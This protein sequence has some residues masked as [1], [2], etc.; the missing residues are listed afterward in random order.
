[1]F[2]IPLFFWGQ[3][4]LLYSVASMIFEGA[5]GCQ[6]EFDFHSTPMIDSV[7]DQVSLEP[8]CNDPS[9]RP[10]FLAIL[11]S[12]LEVMP[13][14]MSWWVAMRITHGFTILFCRVSD[15]LN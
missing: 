1:M 4:T 8:S 9:V 15:Q 6:A 13:S 11:H 12:E 10:A 5:D 3:S 14:R 2:E 7:R